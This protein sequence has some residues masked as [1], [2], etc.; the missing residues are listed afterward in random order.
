MKRVIVNFRIG[1]GGRF[2][3]QG[4]LT[5]DGIGKSLAHY[6]EEN[7]FIN[8]ENFQSVLQELENRVD[9][10][11]NAIY[12]MDDVRSDMFDGMLIK[13]DF[14][15]KYGLAEGALGD[16]Y[17]FDCNGNGIGNLPDEAGNYYF[18]IDGEYNTHYGK[19]IDSWFDLSDREQNVLTDEEIE[20]LRG[21]DVEDLPVVED[22]IDQDND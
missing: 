3:N 15:E 7:N 8:P 14:C 21:Y 6:V 19:A 20:T 10:E 18:D 4:H 1:R 13:E 11:G 9:E 17:L 12:D 16:D 2:H 5:V 22:E